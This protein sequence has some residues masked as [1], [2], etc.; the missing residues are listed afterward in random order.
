MHCLSLWLLPTTLIWPG[1][2]L[3]YS[4]PQFLK[5][6]FP[7]RFLWVES[8]FLQVTCPAPTV[9]FV[10]SSLAMALPTP[11]PQ[12][13]ALLAPWFF[14]PQGPLEASNIGA[15]VSTG[16]RA[17]TVLQSLSRVL[18]KPVP[19]HFACAIPNIHYRSGSLLFTW[20]SCLVSKH[21]PF[22]GPS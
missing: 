8:A 17:G 3:L 7:H 4:A 20:F 13:L 15:I 14:H 1:P 18:G 21:I 16:S 10:C 22:C 11:L 19:P 12:T 6:C 5:S 2:L 9:T